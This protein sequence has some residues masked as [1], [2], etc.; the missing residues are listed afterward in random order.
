MA[1]GGTSV[2]GIVS[3]SETWPSHVLSRLA[4]TGVFLMLIRHSCPHHLLGRES[5][6]ALSGNRHENGS[7]GARGLRLEAFRPCLRRL[8]W[9]TCWCAPSSAFYPGKARRRGLIGGAVR[10]PAGW[11]T[12]FFGRYRHRD[13]GAAGDGDRKKTRRCSRPC[14][15]LP[16]GIEHGTVTVIGDR[17]VVRGDDAA[18]RHR[19]R[20]AAR[21]RPLRPRLAA[22]AERRDFTVKPFQQQELER[23]LRAA[24][25]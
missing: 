21:G 9:A 23:V 3:D 2:T 11:V 12:S 8:S 16:T 13:D 15:R 6:A 24:L 19:H 4:A 18:D 5:G 10:N 14:D 17:R 1:R 20:R 7:A 25:A 22:D